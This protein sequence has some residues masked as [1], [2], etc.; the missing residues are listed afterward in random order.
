MPKKIIEDILYILCRP[1]LP[2]LTIYLLLILPGFMEYSLVANSKII[3]GI[4]R[5]GITISLCST[6]WQ[7]PVMFE[8]NS[9]KWLWI[10]KSTLENPASHKIYYIGMAFIWCLGMGGFIYYAFSTFLPELRGFRFLAPAVNAII[11]AGLFRWR[12]S[13]F[14]KLVKIQKV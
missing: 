2:I 1:L 7:F 14:L 6:Y 5:L 9:G 10:T 4:I 3:D 11:I 13:Y 12:Y 8:P